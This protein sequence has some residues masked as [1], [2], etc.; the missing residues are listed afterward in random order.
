MNTY[1][2]SG[3]S[4][5]TSSFFGVGFG[6]DEQ[7]PPGATRT[8]NTEAWN[9]TSWTEVNN[10]GTARMDLNYGYIGTG[11]NS[12]AL[13]GDTPPYVATTETFTANLGNKTITST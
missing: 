7:I 3:G 13:G 9:G 1:H 2:Q 11:S 12:M 10:M 4:G 8:A 5:G 6:G